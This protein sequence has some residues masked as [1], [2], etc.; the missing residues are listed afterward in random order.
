[1]T[2]MVTLPIV[3]VGVAAVKMSTDLNATMANVNALIPTATGRITELKTAVQDMAISTGK[4]TKDLAGGLYE[5]ISALGDSADTT[6]ILEINAKAAAA[7][8]A[9]TQEALGLT[10]A[11]TKAYGDTSAEAFTKA[12]DLA[13]VAVNLGQTT[14]PELA[15]AIGQVV[16]MAA[17]MRVAQEELFA[18]F[19]SLTG[20]TGN[21][22][23]V[24]TQ[25]SSVLRAMIKPT[26]EMSAV[27]KALG[28][29]SSETMVQQLGLV[30]SVQALMSKTDGTTEAAGK[31][32]G[33]AEALNA[34]FALTGP[35]A[36][37]VAVKME[38]MKT[39]A[40]ETE[41]AFKVQTQGV[42]KLGFEWNQLKA[43]LE[44]TAQTLGD[45]MAPAM[46]SVLD[47]A[48][49]MLDTVAGLAKKF[50]EAPPW[51]QKATV[52]VLGITAA[53]GPMLIVAGSI[54]K[55][56][57]SVIGF[58]GLFA[59]ASATVAT[60]ATGMT[61][62]LAGASAMW[63]SI[64]GVVSAA[65]TALLAFVSSPVTLTVAA[66]AGLGFTIRAL[67]GSWDFIT[68][69]AMYV[70]GILKDLWTI[71]SSLS[72]ILWTVLKPALAGAWEIFKG[73]GS[74]L[75]DVVV[76]SIS[77]VVDWLKILLGP[78]GWVIDKLKWLIGQGRQALSDAASMSATVAASLKDQGIP[79]VPRP[80]I[81][82]GTP[83]LPPVPTMTA[84]PKPKPKPTGPPIIT[85]TGDLDKSKAD[86]QIG[87]A[88]KSIKELDF[89][90]QAALRNG[91]PMKM[92]LAEY[93]SALT[94]VTNKHR[95]FEDRL[96]TLPSSIKKVADARFFEEAK[97]WSLGLQSAA[98]DVS[99]VGIAMG[100]LPATFKKTLDT[101]TDVQTEFYQKNREIGKS[102]LDL[103]LLD[104]EASRK[105]AVEKLGTIPTDPFLKAEWNK[106]KAAIDDYF[107]YQTKLATRS[108]DTIVD[109]MRK[110]GVAT[111][112]DLK[113][114]ASDARLDFE[115]M[116]ESV[117]F[118]AQAIEDAWLAWYEADKL[119]RG[120]WGDSFRATMSSA[121][122][123]V[124]DLMKQLAD[125]GGESFAG[126]AQW[127]GTVA[128]AIEAAAAAT[129]TLQLGFAQLTDGKTLSGLTNLAAGAMAAVAAMDAAT[130]TGSRGQ[131]AMGGAATGAQLGSAFGAWGAAAGAVVGGLIGAFRS[132]DADKVK[133]EIGQK[134]GVSISD[135]LGE[136]I[137]KDM[138]SI[139]KGERNNRWKAELW[140]LG[141]IIDEAGGVNLTNIGKF[142]TSVREAF[143]ML[144]EGALSTAEVSKIVGDVWPRMAEV[145]K[146]NGGLIT[147]EMREIMQLD[148]QF[149]TKTPGISEWILN[150][151]SSAIA[152][153]QP[154]L[155]TWKT[156]S[157]SVAE[158]REQMR[159][160]STERASLD[161]TGAGGKDSAR[162]NELD[163]QW[164]ALSAKLSK[165][166]ALQDIVAVS[167][168]TAASAMGAALAGSFAALTANGVS[169]TDALKQIEP[170]AIA[171]RDQLAEAGY[172][173]GDAF[174][175]LTKKI[176]LVKDEVSGPAIESMQGLG[177]AIGELFNAG[178]L[179]EDMFVGLSGQ[180]GAMYD[181]LK[182]QGVEGPAVL[183]LM[184]PQLQMIWQLQQEFGY[185]VDASTQSMLDE[186]VAAGV[187]GE[188][189]K[190][191]Q[192]KMADG[193]VK[194]VDRL[195]ALLTGMGI[196]LP[197][198]AEKGLSAAGRAAK[199]ASKD[200]DDALKGIPRVIDVDVR[201]RW[202]ETGAPPSGGGTPT[203]PY[204]GVPGAADGVFATRPMLRVFG[205]GG[206]PELGGPVDFMSKALVGA[207]AR[208]GGMGGSS[209]PLIGSIVVQGND[210]GELK[211]YIDRVFL[212]ALIETL[213]RDRGGNGTALVTALRNLGLSGS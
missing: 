37:D 25:L 196:A 210:T 126:I 29:N 213:G 26:E 194:V 130:R 197:L 42:N 101:I 164:D 131:R 67:T 199:N 52:A 193:I 165:T 183:E 152:N 91:V 140:N 19:A 30:G 24:S 161:D 79:T 35:L 66:I 9:T 195:D 198:A 129:D 3:G 70:W 107:T 34:V 17:K 6:K 211:N 146:S 100:P 76:G 167:S 88:K 209:A 57:G 111:R 200:I 108:S 159:K 115:Q 44:V 54:T 47:L 13:F 120:A 63:T 78:L 51:I 143:V 212:P 134:L 150:M 7:G 49:P 62:A 157:A 45:A 21:T 32:F 128:S 90:L 122:G 114:T 119:A 207:L 68:K 104:I 204:D 53:L 109:R 168:Q 105:D 82:P 84:P 121:F 138:K 98:I 156:T 33:R 46:K 162:I 71:V 15:A 23:E 22:S 64:V 103:Q 94:D 10:T 65:G 59:P 8:L 81:R 93:G 205:E 74:T 12:S 28:Y 137:E 112:D 133:K 155:A 139:F 83:S 39:A 123:K 173:G 206:E 166:L 20:V 178:V 187:V 149:G 135:G 132:T 163:K 99:K 144:D 142:S 182:A 36:D 89:A 61:V 38:R 56:I 58:F 55:A 1:M 41:L 179:T 2:A 174:D 201:A 96:G 191:A 80:A 176:A 69:P 50:A 31:L 48:K 5:V 110:A 124:A 116:K 151:S 158:L 118:T 169:M 40:G 73:F 95:I 125:V 127:V 77:S 181:K 16:P 87:D 92:I 145:V 208:V 60:G 85:G 147:N 72:S 106:G 148:Q 202:S 160:I 192:D 141:A 186:A 175:S 113:Q 97:K 117:E 184:K 102:G 153:M 188:A 86:D 189:H 185:S 154:M 177:S 14:F 180:I 4:G 27:V 136:Q 43:K 170:A 172:T 18:G 190:S 75:K 171:L 11:V 203:D